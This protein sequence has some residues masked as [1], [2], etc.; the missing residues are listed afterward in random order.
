MMS[1]NE[2]VGMAARVIHSA[3]AAPGHKYWLCGQGRTIVY[4]PE[5]EVPAAAFKIF[6]FNYQMV[7][8]GLSSPEWGRLEAKVRALC[9]GGLL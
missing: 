6:Q 7:H 8:V 3:V 2:A 9:E 5:A 1:T 4:Y